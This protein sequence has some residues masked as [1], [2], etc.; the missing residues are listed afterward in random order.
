MNWVLMGVVIYIVLFLGTVIGTILLYLHIS[1]NMDVNIYDLNT[2]IE[3]IGQKGLNLL[4]SLIISIVVFN[5]IWG[6]IIIVWIIID[7]A[8]N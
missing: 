3:K 8:G 5:L 4:S 7:R 2:K 6:I 1:R